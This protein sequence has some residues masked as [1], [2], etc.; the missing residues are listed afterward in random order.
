MNEQSAVLAFPVAVVC[1][2]AG[3]AN[4]VVAWV[5]NGLLGG[6]CRVVMEGPARKIWAENGLDETILYPV[7]TDALC[8]VACLISGTGW[9]SNLE[10]D[11][12]VLARM[13]NLPVIA[14]LDHWVNYQLRFERQGKKLLPDELWVTDSDAYSLAK[15]EFPDIHV[16][17]MKNSYISEIV[18]NISAVFVP[19]GP[20]ESSILYVLEPARSDWGRQGSSGEFQ[21][22]DYFIANINLLGL[23]NNPEI[24]LRPHPSDLPGKYDQWIALH[25]EF[26]VRVDSSSDLACAI[27]HA[28]CV[29][30]CQTYAMVV[31][32][33]AGKKVISSLPPWALPSSLPHSEI[34]ILAAM[35][36]NA[37]R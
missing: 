19:A 14:V 3:A 2:D 12:R 8:D 1:H 26:K 32:L 11:A 34:L 6:D 31:A 5:K 4:H 16:R 10:H 18:R 7:L 33:G 37:G 9:G 13:R 36:E 23:G 17:Q 25:S 21:A 28:Q 35:V 20:V 30:G 22:L 15:R 24:V 29:V 27:A